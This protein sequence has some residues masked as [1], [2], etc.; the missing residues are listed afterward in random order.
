MPQSPDTT[1]YPFDRLWANGREVRLEEI[2][3][4]PGLGA[5]PFEKA[6][7]E[8]IAD[9][10]SGKSSFEL[11]T[12]GSTGT[13]KAVSVTRTQ[14]IASA[15]MTEQALMLRQGYRSLVCLD[16][17]YIA[18]KMMLVR[19]LVTGMQMILADPAANPLRHIPRS[20]Q[21]DF[22]AFVPYQ[23]YELLSSSETRYLH[24][25]S[26]VIVGGAPLHDDARAKLLHYPSDWYETYGM[27]ET[28]SHV[29]LK[30]LTHSAST[31]FEALPG[32]KLSLDDRGCLVIEAPH[33]NGSVVT[34][35]VVALQS[36]TA[37]AWLGRWD[38][39]INT[40]GVKVI[41]EHVEPIV[42]DVLQALGITQASFLAGVPD[43]RLG[44][45]VV[46]FLETPPLAAALEKK[47]IDRLGR[48]VPPYHAPKEVRCTPAFS[49]TENGKIA[50]Q[51]TIEIV[52]KAV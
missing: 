22:A 50:R 7:F 16:A 12:S 28:L 17:R 6:A 8:F 35:D 15:R 49:R 9:W 33:L 30:K 27:T 14:L 10:Y 47:I 26:K 52:T 19:S 45:R 21:A 36:P 51:K 23:V 34:N 41:P 43:T 37:F 44:Q 13:P 3:A 5:T 42:R 29:A 46:L 25:I 1:V 48:A 4:R 40:G 18:G 31:L 20:P 24:G 39:V 32:V 11:H 2:L 38:N